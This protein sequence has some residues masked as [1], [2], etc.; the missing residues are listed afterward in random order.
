MIVAPYA[1]SLQLVPR[2]VAS[3]SRTYLLDNSSDTPHRFI[4][5]YD[6]GKLVRIAK[7]LPIWFVTSMLDARPLG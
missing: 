3:S 7:C 2:A 4:A 6:A 5:E 1:R